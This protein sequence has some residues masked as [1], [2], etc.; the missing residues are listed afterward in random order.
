MDF[1]N[2]PAMFVFVDGLLAPRI[3]PLFYRSFASSVALN[4]DETVLEFGGGSGGISERL[5]GRLKRGSLTCM[6]ICPPMLEIAKRRLRRFPQARCLLGRIENLDLET[7]SLDVVVIHNALH[8]LPEAE[9]SAAVRT[10]ASLLKSGG[11]LHFREPTK[12]PHGFPA[13]RYRDL[14]T[15]A[16]LHEIASRE[17]KLFPIGPVVHA[18]FERQT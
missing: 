12:S 4:G 1:V 14:M 15:Q 9:R 8:D 11:R 13:E 18:V 5:A 16:G 2:P 10:L 6:D 7:G 3:F 17:Y